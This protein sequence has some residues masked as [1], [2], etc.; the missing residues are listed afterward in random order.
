M[1]VGQ[2]AAGLPFLKT[3][4]AVDPANA[5]YSLSYAD[6]LLAGGHAREALNVL[7]NGNAAR[8]Q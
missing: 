7:T 8:T 3:A 5:Q 6:A 4:L 1:Q 2:H